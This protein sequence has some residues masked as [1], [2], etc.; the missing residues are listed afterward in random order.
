MKVT[1][2]TAEPQNQIEINRHGVPVAG[3]NYLWYAN[4]QFDTTE[5]WQK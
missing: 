1:H 2:I 4:Q 3:M 5:S